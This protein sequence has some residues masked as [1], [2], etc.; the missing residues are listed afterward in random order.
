MW[1]I[2]QID[3]TVL[4]IDPTGFLAPA[5]IEGESL[6]SAPEGGIVV[7]ES[8]KRRGVQLGDTLRITGAE[9]ELTVIGF[10]AGQTYNHIPVI[11]M[12]LLRWRSLKF[13]AP[14]SDRGVVDPVSII[15]VQMDEAAATQVAAT[16]SGVEIVTPKVALDHLPGYKEEQSSILMIEVFLFVIAAFIVA[17]F[18][19]VIT[20]QKTNQFG[21][22]KAFGA[23][24]G[25]LA[26]GLIGQV[27]CLSLIG[28]GLGALLTYSVAA[29]MPESI[30]FNLAREIVVNYSAVLL[31]VAL[32]GAL[33]SLRQ[34]ATID[35][36][37]AIGR[38]D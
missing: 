5:I 32:G 16:L 8:M 19:Y 20:L 23:S 37:I 35:P 11:F 28:I 3:V 7:D 29:I 31:L 15:A 1:E 38:I 12:D 30:P 9:M 25:F 6:V 10:T 36:L 14:G 33:L 17:V 22:L 34:I 13:A 2:L 18:F 4:A 21:V 27:L 26:R 24:T